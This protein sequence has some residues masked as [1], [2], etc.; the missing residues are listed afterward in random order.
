MDL[1]HYR[2]SNTEQ[3]RIRSLLDLIP[4]K[5]KSALDIGARDGYISVLLTDFFDTVT[6]LDLEMPAIDHHAVTCVKGNAA[7]LDFPDNAF[8]LVLCSEVLEH[9]PAAMLQD[10]CDEI[11]RVASDA[12][13]I[14]VPYKQDIRIGRTTCH[15]CGGKNPPWGHVNT[16][17]EQA[18]RSLFPRLHWNRAVF[19]GENRFRTNALSVMLM[20]LAGNP[21]GVY[22]Q[23]EICI[24]CGAR[25]KLPT[26]RSLPQKV[27]TRISTLIA[28]AQTRFATARPNWIN[29]RFSKKP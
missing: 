6:A 18:L 23:E 27:A 22:D 16:F 28:R 7:A 8:D 1:E 21:Y 20:D 9:I 17:D 10:V 26:E 25:L 2:E 24:H 13:I 12:V 4:R 15:A 11:T 3:Q 29:V 14:G 19:A 5:G